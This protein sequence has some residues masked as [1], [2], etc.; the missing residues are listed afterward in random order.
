MS[1]QRHRRRL[2][3]NNRFGL[4]KIVIRLDSVI[5]RD[6]DHGP[7]F[8]LISYR[9]A[10]DYRHWRPARDR[11]RPAS[12]PPGRGRDA[13]AAS[14]GDD[15]RRYALIRATDSCV[16][17]ASSRRRRAARRRREP[18]RKRIRTS[19]SILSERR[20]LM[21]WA[22]APLRVVFIRSPF[23]LRPR[24]SV[25]LTRRRGRPRRGLGLDRRQRAWRGHAQ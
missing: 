24:R 6:A 17:T 14:R 7:V 12:K 9:L 1:F 10:L 23:R 5:F 21:M 20:H 8:I 22:I 13:R 4:A 15:G 2:A 19:F 11:F 16:R 25:R 18:R 3:E